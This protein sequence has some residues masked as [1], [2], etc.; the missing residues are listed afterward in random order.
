[1]H[2]LISLLEKIPITDEEIDQLLSFT[3]SEDE[4]TLELVYET[5]GDLARKGLYYTKC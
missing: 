1:M 3:K 2:I 5:F 4:K